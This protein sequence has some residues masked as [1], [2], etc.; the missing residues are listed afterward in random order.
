MTPP[1]LLNQV[2]IEHVSVIRADE[3]NFTQTPGALA[4]VERTMRA[5]MALSGDTGRLFTMMSLY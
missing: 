1:F 4:N 3:V 2:L 5:R